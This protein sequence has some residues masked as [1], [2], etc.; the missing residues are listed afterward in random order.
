MIPRPAFSASLL[1]AAALALAP[2]AHAE[3][4]VYLGLNLV[5]PQTETIQPDAYVVVEDG[6]IV[7][8]GQGRPAT[9]QGRMHDFTGLF[10]LP[11]LIDTHAHI[12]LAAVRLGTDE[13]GTPYLAADHRPDIVAHNARRLLAY[14]VTTV[15][16]PGGDMTASRAYDDA[17]AAGLPGP[18][19]L[20][21]GEVIDRSPFP[22]I[23]LADRPSEARGVAAIV[24][25]QAQGRA[26]YIKLYE[27]L[28]EADLIEGIAEARR[29][30]LPVIAHLSD[31]SWTRAA[32]LGVDALVHMMPVSPDL[33]PP[34][35]REA[36]V[37][38]RRQGAFAFF[39][40]YEAVDLDA[41]EIE[42]MIRTLARE[43]VHVDAT[44]VAFEAAFR[45][46]D[47]AFLARD[48]GLFHPD[49][50]ANWS[51]VFRF[52]LGWTAEDYARARAVW[53][54]VLELT[55]RMHEAGVPL[56]LG[57]DMANPFIAPGRSMAREAVLHQ[58]A[59]I[60]AWDVL[61]MAT[62]D[63]ARRLG[64]ADRTGA[65]VVGQ[66][67]DIVFL[68]ADP[69]TDLNALTQVRAVLSDGALHDP[70]TLLADQ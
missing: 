60:P 35:R 65:L 9:G 28:S 55:R 29:H 69:A 4:D 3:P 46:D 11:G 25:E 63:A 13:T 47:A 5:D 16:N 24:A 67:A 32:E 68:S 27:S 19:A 30:G 17:R 62:T 54:K 59:G 52:D 38:S 48:A 8:I 6:R 14:G 23:G 44:L 18:E 36:Y 57:T 10:A 31:V 21:A 7:E 50:Q 53:P 37:A 15:R 41:P 34:D 40:W 56:T 39:E 12:S 42:T 22:V 26:R 33:L 66:E 70:E 61:R 49:M 1:A 45:G 58:E 43:Q 20:H 64:I 51:Q 2:A